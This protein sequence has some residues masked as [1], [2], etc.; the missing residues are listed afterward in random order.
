[1]H[2]GQD[3]PSNV[4]EFDIDTVIQKSGIDTSGIS[5]HP[6]S[7]V[8]DLWISTAMFLDLKNASECTI[9]L[10][11]HYNH[12]HKNLNSK[13]R[14]KLKKE[15]KRR[16]ATDMDIIYSSIVY[17]QIG[18]DPLRQ[19][20]LLKCD[21]YDVYLWEYPLRLVQIHTKSK[22]GWFAIWLEGLTGFDENGNSCQVPLS[23]YLIS[24][25][26]R[27]ILI[28]S[29]RCKKLKKQITFEC[30]DHYGFEIHPLLRIRL[31]FS[32]CEFSTNDILHSNYRGIYRGPQ[33]CSI[34]SKISKPL[35]CHVFSRFENKGKS[36]ISGKNLSLW[37]ISI[38]FES[39][40]TSEDLD[41]ESSQETL[42]EMIITEERRRQEHSQWQNNALLKNKQRKRHFIKKSI[43]EQRNTC[44]AFSQ[45]R[46]RYYK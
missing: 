40:E 42:Q 24:E 9:E 33:L 28:Q 25:G 31:G 5:Y 12:M 21:T 2:D 44:R 29:K 8:S 4:R 39:V 45:Q 26:K 35:I 17:A 6:P 36:P 23:W 19:L 30:V 14:R 7:I 22:Y 1:M 43:P 41:I 34:A 18:C 46:S 15:K 32:I 38:R 37:F 11:D 16:G 20:L 3:F 10:R 13:K 27:D